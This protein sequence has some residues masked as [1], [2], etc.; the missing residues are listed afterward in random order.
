MLRGSGESGETLATDL[1][2]RF[3]CID[4][5]R[6]RGPWFESA[7]I[8]LRRRRRSVIVNSGEVSAAALRVEGKIA[9]R[10]AEDSCASELKSRLSRW[11][12]DIGLVAGSESCASMGRVRA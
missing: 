11:R 1:P 12:V 4:G 3:H 5:H 10:V 2:T 8:R 9:A 7:A 6:C